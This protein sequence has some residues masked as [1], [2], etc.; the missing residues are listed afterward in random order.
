M[1]PY[2]KRCLNGSIKQSSICCWECQWFESERSTVEHEMIEANRWTEETGH[3]QSSV[4]R[5]W[6]SHPLTVQP[7]THTPQ[8][9]ACWEYEAHTRLSVAWKYTDPIPMIIKRIHR[10]TTPLATRLEYGRKSTIIIG[11]TKKKKTLDTWRKRFDMDI[12]C[13]D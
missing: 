6:I 12:A 3:S 9:R 11:G 4:P 5:E 13:I 1:Q 8:A 10:T 7:R 2:T